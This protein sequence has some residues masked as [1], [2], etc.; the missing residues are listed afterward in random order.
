M[1]T[2]T[3]LEQ[4]MKAFLH[5]KPFRPFVIELEDGQQW[6][7]GQPEAVFY[8]TGGTGMFFHQ[9]GSMD[10]LDCENVKQLLELATVPPK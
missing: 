5:R 2:R 10:F 9:D 3:V 7:V 8:H 1:M 6:V 4:T